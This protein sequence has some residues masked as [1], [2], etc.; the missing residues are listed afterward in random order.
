M[1]SDDPRLGALRYSRAYTLTI[2]ALHTLCCAS[3]ST[4]ERLQ[5]VDP[6]FFAL[7]PN[8]LPENEGVRASFEKL[9]RLATRLEPR[10][11]EEGKVSA[12]LAQSHHTKLKEMAQLVWDI[13]RGF[14]RY[15]QSDA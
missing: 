4:R 1:K 12:T 2:E 9:H 5:Q 13:H 11:K 6:E 8:D 14:S 3:G 7:R 15:M 10:W